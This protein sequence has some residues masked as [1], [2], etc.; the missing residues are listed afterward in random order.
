[1]QPY[2]NKRDAPNQANNAKGHLYLEIL[3][4]RFLLS[5]IIMI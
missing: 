3:V 4:L 1:M 2:I 5:L